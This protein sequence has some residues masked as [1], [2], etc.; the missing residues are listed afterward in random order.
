MAIIA[1]AKESTRSASQAVTL[2]LAASILIRDE[3]NVDATL[4]SAM[5][6]A[7]VRRVVL[8]VVRDEEQ[9]PS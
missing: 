6:E 3:F 7:I 2:L 9:K 4:A 5:C 1:C 8:K